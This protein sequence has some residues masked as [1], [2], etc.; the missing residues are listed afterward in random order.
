VRGVTEEGG[1]ARLRGLVDHESMMP[2]SVGYMQGLEGRE[3]G[4][5]LDVGLDSDL[6]GLLNTTCFTSSLPRIRLFDTAVR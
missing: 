1:G 2:A 4:V 6:V 5:A 3:A